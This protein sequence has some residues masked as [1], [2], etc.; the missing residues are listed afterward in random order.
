MYLRVY[1]LVHI[2]TY[3]EMQLNL[4]LKVYEY[5]YIIKHDDLQL[6]SDAGNPVGSISL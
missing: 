1:G 2:C 5:I 6:Y 4:L 3:F